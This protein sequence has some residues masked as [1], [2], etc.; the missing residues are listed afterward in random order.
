[1]RLLAALALFA[2]VLGAGIAGAAWWR[3]V[4][5][6][7]SQDEP[8]RAAALRYGIDA[9]LVKAVIWRES[10]FLP[11]AR[12]SSGE[13]GLMQLQA[14]AAHEW[15]DAEGIVGFQHGHCLDPR[16]NTLAG[17]FYLGK[18][19]KRYRHTDN[20]V[21]YALADYNA[22][23]ANVLKWLDGAG[24]T[25]SGTFIQQIGFPTTRKYVRQVLKRSRR[26]HF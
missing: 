21:P 4:Q 20:P 11:D 22:G 14:M 10:G 1:M 13:L 9:A 24:A 16:T 23:R 15:A 2:L 3:R 18:L 7:R 26:Y 19:L 5:L 17:A 25:N 8:I 6:E 12:G